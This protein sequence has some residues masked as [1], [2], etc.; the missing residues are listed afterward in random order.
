MP[1]RVMRCDW[2]KKSLSQTGH[3]DSLLI[4]REKLK[5]R[6]Y[7]SWKKRANEARFVGV[8]ISRNSVLSGLSFNRFWVIHDCKAKVHCCSALKAVVT[9]SGV[10][11]M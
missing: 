8:P 3:Q 11:L 7:I 6:V 9:F 1:Y 4:H 10:R 2:K 5:T